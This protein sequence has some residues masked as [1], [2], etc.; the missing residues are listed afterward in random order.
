[1]TI[2]GFTV[3]RTNILI[4]ISAAFL[5]LLTENNMVTSFLIF[6]LPLHCA[7]FHKYE[8]FKIILR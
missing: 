1:M 6:I 5:F 2:G 3:N 7:P 4:T 8:N